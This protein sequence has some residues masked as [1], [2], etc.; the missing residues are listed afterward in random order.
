MG[1]NIKF[2]FKLQAYLPAHIGDHIGDKVKKYC[3]EKNISLSKGIEEI[4]IKF[5]QAESATE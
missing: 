3:A 1:K 4:L 5:F 2:T